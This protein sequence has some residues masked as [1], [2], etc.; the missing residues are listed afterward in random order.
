MKYFFLA[1]VIGVVGLTIYFA[2]QE[3]DHTLYINEIEQLRERKD[4]NFKMEDSPIPEPDRTSFTGLQYYPV[5]PDFR[6]MAKLEKNSTL[7]RVQLPS[8]TGQDLIYLVYG[9][10]V[11]KLNGERY[12]LILLQETGQGSSSRLFLPFSDETSARETYGGG[13][14]LDLDFDPRSTRVTI[15]FNK[16][17]FPYCAYKELYTCAIP[18]PQNNLPVPIKAGEKN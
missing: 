9:K 8:S 17:Y 11:F 5:D 12:S 18:P 2:F 14:Y 10:A 3:E 6:V 13:R 1:I 15:D 4:R 7:E 16:A